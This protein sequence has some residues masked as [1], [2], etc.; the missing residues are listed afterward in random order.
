MEV[1]KQRDRAEVCPWQAAGPSPVESTHC[2]LG[3]GE[4]PVLLT[5]PWEVPGGSLS[6]RTQEEHWSEPQKGG[7]LAHRKLSGT[8]AGPCLPLAV[9]QTRQL[10][11]WKR[12]Q[13]WL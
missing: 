9:F 4:L 2:S 13:G 3:P 5:N 10:S 7:S 11:W 8:E 12:R 6:L 1:E